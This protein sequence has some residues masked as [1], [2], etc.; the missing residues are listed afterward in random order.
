MKVEIECT[1]E[2]SK[3]EGEEKV[4][5]AHCL[6][7]DLVNC[8]DRMDNAV[9]GLKKLIA[10]QL[11]WMKWET[12]KS[13][14]VQCGESVEEVGKKH[15]GELRAAGWILAEDKPSVLDPSGPE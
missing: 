8:D 14:A 4:W 12:L 7:L 5:V 1:V 9:E 13:M 11:D 15:R 3:H 10:I 6:P 2:K